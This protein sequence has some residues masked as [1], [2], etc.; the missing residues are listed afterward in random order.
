MIKSVLGFLFF[1]ACIASVYH[2][3]KNL[4]TLECCT[5]AATVLSCCHLSH[6]AAQILLLWPESVLF[7]CSLSV[8]LLPSEPCC[9]PN[10]A[11]V[12]WVSV[13]L[14]QPQCC[15]VAIWAMLQPKFC[16]CGLSQCCSVAASVLYCCIPSTV[17]LWP[18]CCTVASQVL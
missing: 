4:M 18:K 10:S 13:V 5:V 9:S 3:L 8:V 15:T 16:Y 17:M 7:C 12:A 1:K 2:V 14:L 11:I 6:A